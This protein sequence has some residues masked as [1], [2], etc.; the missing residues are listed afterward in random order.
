MFCKSL[1][2]YSEFAGFLSTS[3]VAK[4]RKDKDDKLR[5]D[6]DDGKDGAEE[7]SNIAMGTATGYF[8]NVVLFIKDNFK[9][10]NFWKTRTIDDDISKIRRAIEVSMTKE[11]IRRGVPVTHKAGLVD[12]E[13][14]KL[15]VDAMMMAST[16]EGIE[17]SSVVC[18]SYNGVSRGGESGLL[19]WDG[20]T[21]DGD[22][23]MINFRWPELKLGLY[24]PMAMGCSR[25]GYQLCFL[26]GICR[27]F[28][29]RI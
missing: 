9:D 22:Q 19:S 3:C 25:A 11:C 4:L 14:L 13:V 17:R 12:L 28:I 16:T 8:G 29:F 5:K 21:Y 24:K 18:T 6:G 10:N 15:V 26:N 2:I 20:C 7:E 1:K 27:F 23:D